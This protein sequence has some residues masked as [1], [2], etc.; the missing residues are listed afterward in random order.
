MPFPSSPHFR[1][2][3]D[4]T[5]LDAALGL[6]STFRSGRARVVHAQGRPV[7]GSAAAWTLNYAEVMTRTE[8]RSGLREEVRERR[9]D[10]NARLVRSLRRL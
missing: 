2:I 3:H 1:A 5:K 4:F 9:D 8:R 6:L 10:V 7:Q